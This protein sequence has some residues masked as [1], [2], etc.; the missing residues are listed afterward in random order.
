MSFP[1]F[2][3]VATFSFVFFCLQGNLPPERAA[4]I[5]TKPKPISFFIGLFF[6]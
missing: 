4:A 6:D 1:I 2:D 3:R 5:N